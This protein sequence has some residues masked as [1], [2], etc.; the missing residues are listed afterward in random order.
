MTVIHQLFSLLTPLE[1]RNLFFLCLF[2]VINAL[3]QIFG[4]AS[5]APLLA[6]ITSPESVDSIPMLDR[7]TSLHDFDSHKDLSIFLGFLILAIMFSGNAIILLTNY[8]S[9]RYANN[10]ECSIGSK[11]LKT[12]LYQPYV[13]FL[14]RNSSEL[15]RNV[16]N[17]VAYIASNIISRF[18]NLLT[19]SISAFGI[20]V[21]IFIINPKITLILSVTL[22][23]AYALTYL[24]VKKPLYGFGKRNVELTETKLRAVNDSIRVIKD[25]RMQALEPMFIDRF[26]IA[27]REYA[28]GRTLSDLAGIMPKYIIEVFAIAALVFV[29]IFLISSHEDTSEILPILGIYAFAGFRLMPAMQ[30][31][32]LAVSKIQFSSHSLKLVANEVKVYQD[33]AYENEA[34]A[35]DVV[36]FEKSFALESVSFSYGE[37][38]PVVKD[39]N[40]KISKGEKIGIVGKS[41]EGKSTIIDV[42]VGLTTP[43]SGDL[44]VDG[45]KVS[46]R[47][48]IKGW[49]HKIAYTSQ[50]ACLLDDTIDMNISLEENAN[51]RDQKKLDIAKK[52][53]H[54][55]FQQDDKS[56][57]ENGQRLSGGQRQRV[58]LA[59]ALYQDKPILVLDEAT[60]AM[61]SDGEANILSELTKLDKTIIY[62]THR[63]ETLKF[64]DKIC[65]V[66]EG[67]IVD[68]GSYDALKKSSDAFKM[69]LQSSKE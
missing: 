4:I 8:L 16:Y 67:K 53:A 49:R 46:S 24:F 64:C 31:I 51:H 29:I 5:V 10:R 38:K 37:E 65:V 9:L 1:K 30:Q 42:L 36:T 63:V 11:L 26:Q 17:E 61:D 62:I 55:D 13:F 44:L 7:V 6:A 69:L 52:I 54:I 32:F 2:M 58:G 25:I 68:S 28:R 27:A 41:G 57:G 22:G 50:N 43:A 19:Y 3:V 47:E 18:L 45:A 40:L 33:I 14:D 23:G 48:A 60:S 20:I 56:V 39:V 15:L 21:F 12:Y 35:M 59:R 34:A 66:S